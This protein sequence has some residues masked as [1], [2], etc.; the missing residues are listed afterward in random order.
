M[1]LKNTVPFQFVFFA[2][3]LG[4]AA[5]EWSQE[6]PPVVTYSGSRTSAGWVELPGGAQVAV[7][8][9]LEWRGT[10]VY[11]SLTWNLVAVDAASG[12]TIWSADVGAFWNELSVKEL[13]GEPG[14]KAWA[15]ELR[16]GPGAS[17]GQDQRQYYDLKTGKKMDAKRDGPSGTKLE[18]KS[19][20]G[21]AVATAAPLRTLIDNE[22]D[23]QEYVVAPYFKDLDS[24]PDFAGLDFTTCVALVVMMGDTVNCNGLSAEAFDNAERTL[25][26]LHPRTLQTFGPDGGAEKHRPWGIFVLPKP[27]PGK[28]II[29]ERNEKH[30]INGPDMWKE[31]VRFTEVPRP[32]T[33]SPWK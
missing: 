1:K 18:F 12:K 5:T 6:K 21:A 14:Q 29:V 22:R 23:F 31:R 3:I 27:A 10:K 7:D 33:A 13:E 2:L 25:V 8:K 15:V 4:C 24:A 32:P 28:L 30:L 16:P 19:W 11:L 20:S 17:Q 9:A 26:R